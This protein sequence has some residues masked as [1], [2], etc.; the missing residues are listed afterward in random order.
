MIRLLQSNWIATALG[1]LLYLVT[2]VLC[3]PHKSPADSGPSARETKKAGPSWTFQNPEMDQLIVELKRA[4][5]GLAEKERQLN[6]LEL[7]LQTERQELNQVTQSVHELQIE[8]DRNVVRVEEQ[9]SVN[10][11][12]LG[13]VYSTMAPDG[14]VLILKQMDESTLTKILA[15]MKE[16][17]AAPI[18]EALAKQG[19]AEAKRA[20]SICERLRLT[21]PKPSNAA[22]ATR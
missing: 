11:K 5:D 4:K 3:W 16:S 21:L 8:F 12:K 13:K 7:R 19:D 22:A 10:L 6:E 20:A 15:L 14:A 1:T 9:E 2:V 17:E 18:L